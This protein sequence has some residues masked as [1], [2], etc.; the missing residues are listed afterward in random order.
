MSM[1]RLSLF[2][3]CLL[4]MLCVPAIAQA[5]NGVDHSLTLPSGKKVTSGDYNA[6][7]ADGAFVIGGSAWPKRTIR[8]WDMTPRGNYRIGVAKAIA[9]WNARGMRVH[10]AKARTRAS[11]DFTIS[12][13]RHIAPGGLATVGY[14]GSGSYWVKLN[15]RGYHWS[16]VAWV[17]S[18][19]LGHIFG[20]GH[21]RGC[22][23][24]SYSAY[25]VCKWPQD[26]GQPWMWRCRLQERDDLMGVKRLYGG[27]F[28]LRPGIFCLKNPASGAVTGLTVTPSVDPTKLATLGWNA[29][30]RAKSYRIARSAP[31]G[32]CPS[33]VTGQ[34][35]DQDSA[36]TY[37]EE[38]SR[39]QPPTEGVY[40]YVVWSVNVDGYV[41]PASRATAQ[42]TY[43]LPP[44][45]PPVVAQGVAQP[46][47]YNDPY[48]PT[49]NSWNVE[50]SA[51]N[52]DPAGQLLYARGCPA[53][54]SEAST[55]YASPYGAEDSLFYSDGFRSGQ[56]VCYRFWASTYSNG[57]T[58]Y[59]PPVDTIV[60][61]P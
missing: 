5:H 9:E 50:L 27:S 3:L 49:Y 1:P 42:L 25:E 32:A 51:T 13:D 29:A 4:S 15:M 24:M 18:H 23:V 54:P 45:L 39:W 14:W 52:P 30:A 47:M 57:L 48:D 20:L 19:E 31:N 61:L 46:D 22:A 58:R 59:S 60:I 6:A 11:A 21:S 2:L 12:V 44:V 16:D 33:N 28:R 56:Q 7:A 43:T 38:I 36:R 53:D 34:Y 8:Y 55:F 40:C 26:V 17:A 37:T 10:F 41:N 35:L